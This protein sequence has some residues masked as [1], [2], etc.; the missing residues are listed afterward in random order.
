MIIDIILVRNV[1]GTW[2]YAEDLL[3]RLACY[4]DP[5]LSLKPLNEV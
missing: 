1:V 5:T 2:K 3:L 4:R